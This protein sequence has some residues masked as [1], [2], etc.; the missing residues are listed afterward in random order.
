MKKKIENM[1]QKQLTLTTQ[2]RKVDTMSTRNALTI[3][4]DE[5]VTGRR[6]LALMR[7]RRNGAKR[8]CP[9][10]QS[11]TGG[12]AASGLPV[13]LALAIFLL[14]TAPARALD[15]DDVANGSWHS[16]MTWDVTGIPA[17]LND[18]VIVDTNTVTVDQPGAMCG[19]LRVDT[20]SLRIIPGGQLTSVN[21][22]V[23]LGH[24]GDIEQTGGQHSVGG[25]LT[26]GLLSGGQ[27]TYRLYDGSLTIQD[28]LRVGMGY[29]AGSANSAGVLYLRCGGGGS[30]QT[31]VVEGLG[32]IIVAPLGMMFGW[33]AMTC[34][35]LLDNS[36]QIEA[37]GWGQDRDLDLRAM[38]GVYNAIDKQ[39]IVT[40]GQ[41]W[42]ARDGGLLLLPPVSVSG[43][44]ICN[45]GESP[46]D[47]D[48]DLVNSVQMTFQGGGG[49]G[50]VDGALLA[51]DRG[52]LLIPQ[53]YQFFS[54]W[55]F[56]GPE[57]ESLDMTF[58]YNGHEF[59]FE[60]GITAEEDLR[61]FRSPDGKTNWQCVGGI[62]D[63]APDHI[64]VL[65]LTGLD[66]DMGYFAVGIPE[67]ATL[68][69]LALGGLAVIRKRRKQLETTKPPGED[70]A[71]Q[72]ETCRIQVITNK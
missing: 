35:G 28:E 2:K 65:G 16:P 48:I 55:H 60:M 20:Y 57:F 49:G 51:L 68:S 25:E 23:A 61:V 8:L 33:G 50:A 38:G 13:V 53:G 47:P 44:G 31:G 9:V 52:E 62:V 40:Y 26:I 37:N 56:D 70:A 19:S 59:E 34:T 54:V 32:N 5:V 71:A 69:L 72:A 11:L 14:S 1:I 43:V 12:S 22:I 6:G 64:T 7:H 27:G 15:Y 41:G 42:R 21:E 30:G 24:A 4:A 18:S 3:D 29:G 36:G 58:C 10:R 63:T 39:E 17:S 66:P 46:D 45:W 67:P